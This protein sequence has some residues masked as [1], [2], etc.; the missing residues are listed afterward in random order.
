MEAI[1]VHIIRPDFLTFTFPI[2]TVED[3]ITINPTKM[4]YT[5][6]SGAEQSVERWFY[7]LVGI[8][9]IVVIAYIELSI[10]PVVDGV[11]KGKRRPLRAFDTEAEVQIRTARAF[12]EQIN[13]TAADFIRARAGRVKGLTATVRI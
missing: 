8:V 2:V 11:I 10:A 9:A 5:Y 7:S 13:L 12:C 1:G 6:I 4:K 3:K